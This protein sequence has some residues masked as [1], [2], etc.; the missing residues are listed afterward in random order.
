MIPLVV[1]RAQLTAANGIFLLTLNAAFAIGFAVL[2]PLLVIVANPTAHHRGRGPL[3]RR[4]RASA[5]R[6][7]R[8]RRGPMPQTG[9]S[10]TPARRSGTFVEQLR[11]GIAYVRANPVVSWALLYLGVAASIVGVLGRPRPGVRRRTSSASGRRTS[12]SSCCR[13]ASAS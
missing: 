4:R 9:P 6:C 1:P 7:P 8:R 5:G 11:E 10:T 2:G 12:W 3:P 13:S